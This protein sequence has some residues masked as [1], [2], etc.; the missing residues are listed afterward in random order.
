MFLVTP[1]TNNSSISPQIL[2]LNSQH[3]ETVSGIKSQNI[4]HYL[5]I[6]LKLYNAQVNIQRIIFIHRN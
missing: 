6:L 2:R 1:S 5:F 3:V 4:N